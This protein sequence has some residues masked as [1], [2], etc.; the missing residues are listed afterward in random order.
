MHPRIPNRS[1]PMVAAILLLALSPRD[2]R[3]GCDNIPS[4]IEQF[5]AARGTITAPYA[6]PGQSLQIRVRPEVCDADSPGLGTA[7]AC[8]ADENLRVTLLFGADGSAPVHA[9]VLARSCGNASD[10]ASLQHAVDAWSATLGAG[11]SATC[12]S[13]PE[14]SLDVDAFDL[15]SVQ[16]CRLGFRFPTA[17]T[18]QLSSPQTLTGPTRIV[19]DPIGSPL[20]TGLVATRCADATLAGGTIACIDD[21][22]RLDGSCSTQTTSRNP[23]FASFTALPVPN[24]FADMTDAA[25]PALRFAL[26]ASGNMLAPMDWTGVLCQTDPNCS[27]EGF[28]PPQL[29]QVEF[30]QSLGSGLNAQG[31]PV[32]AGAPIVIP[33]REFVSSHT[34]Q[35]TELPPIFD[36]FT[37]SSASV[38]GTGSL[39][40]FGSTDA[41]Q[42]V[43]RLQTAAPGRCSADG[44]PC[45]GDAGCAS[46][47]VVQSCD[48]AAPDATVAD[49]RY[50]RHPATCLP[51][52]TAAAA[53]PPSGGPGLVPP[54]LYTAS[55]DGFVPLAALNLCRGE[56]DLGCL[57][58]DEPLA[59]VDKNEDGDQQDPSIITLRERSSGA[60][61]PIGLDGEAQGLAAALL[62]EA[63][64]T[65]GPFGA[66]ILAAPTGASRR[67]TVEAA[68][69][70]AAMLFAEPWENAG[71][72]PGT[73]ANGDGLAF[74]PIL[75][76]FCRDASTPQ[77]V[78][79]V[80]AA[81][82]ANAGLGSLLGASAKPLLLPVGRTSSPF[83]GG[84]EPFV[85]AGERLYFLLDEAANA[86]KTL[87]ERIDVG[88]DGVAATG[89]SS[90]P[91]LSDDGKT[92]CFTSDTNLVAGA[93]GHAGSDVYC[94]DTQDGKTYVVDRFQTSCAA[95]I[96][97][98]N[99]AASAPSVSAEGRRVCF[100]SAASN[101][102][103]G[104]ADGNGV[105]DVFVFDHATCQTARVT[106]TAAGAQAM[107]ASAQCEISGRG[108]TVAFA[109][110][111][112]LTGSDADEGSS[113]VFVRGLLGGSSAAD[114]LRADVPILAS[115]GLTGEA[116][117]P[118]L[119]A[120][121]T[122]VAF[123]LVTPAG[124]RVHVRDL[125]TGTAVDA[126]GFGLVG[127]HPKLS[128][129]GKLL[130]LQTPNATTG[131]DEVF[132]VD[133]A[134]SA[135]QRAI[136]AAPA[137]LTSTLEYVEAA[138]SD[139]DASANAISFASSA[140]LTPAGTTP[141]GSDVYLRDLGTQLLARVGIGGAAGVVSGDGSSVTYVAATATGTGLHRSGITPANALDIDGNGSTRDLV[142]AV[143]DLSTDPPVLDVVGA[144]RHAAVGADTVAFVAPGGR[145]FVRRCAPATS[146]TVEP[147]LMP[148][149]TSPALGSAVAASD[150]IVCA[151]LVSGGHVAC[152]PAGETRL[153]DLGVAGRA[154]GVV[155]ASVVFTTD[156]F[157]SLLRTFTLDAG[158]F[159]D[160]FTGAPGT[161][162]FVLSDNGFAAYDRCERDLNQDL[163]GDGVEDECVLDFVEVA[164][165]H[166][167]ATGATVIP[168]TL[169]TC[170]RR[171]PWRVFPSGEG[172]ASATVRF[173]SVECQEDGNCAACGSGSCA[174]SGR[175]CDLN[176]NG[177]CADVVVRE[178][179]SDQRTVVLAQLGSA[180]DGDPLA[181]SDSGGSFNQGAVFPSLVG[182]CDVDDDPATTPSTTPCQADAHCAAGNVCGPPFS[183]LALNDADGDGVFD[184]FDNCRNAFNP[185]Q[186]DADG[187]GV[188]DACGVVCGNGVVDGDEF[189]DDGARNGACAGLELA[190]CVARGA[191]GS[192]C[193]ATCAPQVF[194]DVSEQ[195]VNPGK[196]GV[197]PTR[198]FGT[199]LLNLGPARPYDGVR[200]AIP[201]G[202]PSAMIDLPSV[203][204]EGVRSGAVCSGAGAP[205]LLSTLT[206]TNADGMLDLQLK[207]QVLQA[208]IERGDD[209]ACTAGAFRRVEGRFRDARFEARDRLN[210]KTK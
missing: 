98:A 71:G 117:R 10:P 137:A 160:V 168:C 8:I 22:Y 9:V 132:V 108:A 102:L 12:Q 91:T 196:Q 112:S 68:G 177:S 123:E 114:P 146:C 199:P 192:F 17:T 7:P 128:P 21:L 126:L 94:R 64:T 92:I 84:G 42:T 15:G 125:K 69:A 135:A 33:S 75:R 45:I 53:T 170:D 39:A 165:G 50:C 36:P 105:A 162:R 61:L 110:A 101:L 79:E 54:A 184:G 24:D 142:L 144:A 99:A 205:V 176:A 65:I 35:G 189:C 209:Q 46:D 190:T 136:V 49:L 202:C 139:G 4:E 38:Q 95:P 59:G 138:S 127:R 30:P 32:A 104:A 204:L 67:P 57:L 182:R 121:G 13:V 203:R 157:P 81:A 153:R 43:I 124:T 23:R 116:G 200:C 85:L 66:P 63:P 158:T 172:A 171:F 188:G 89:S 183:V 174:P 133:I 73:D 76:V 1:F 120:S 5:R 140:A 77:G 131:A 20:P 88:S 6:I 52:G 80:A 2:A 40:L 26:D 151:L 185:G 201:G 86:V 143:L 122:L 206:D 14:G 210:L 141:G 37:S 107:A 180:V 129:D 175:D 3:A 27:V 155:G 47:P 187:D 152:A 51:P 34:L 119:S 100:E 82:A 166:S 97:R 41:V 163:N 169:E 207:Y 72:T 29:I 55:T 19:V 87:H 78:R 194:V 11:G 145:V 130:T 90:E 93:P 147:L 156:T 28:P 56:G 103:A 48:L 178:I 195:A 62:H 181:G 191:A 74:E 96:V 25:R 16:E 148:D 154:L 106:S 70:C 186:E 134:A 150:E 208:R 173:L 197:L 198:L 109:S 167:S 118:S 44:T 193:D 159:V 83:Q 164:T 115:A 18:P 113:D 161:R 58:R 179:T 60:N 31:A 111:A 149:G